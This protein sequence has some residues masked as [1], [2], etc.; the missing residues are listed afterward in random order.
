MKNCGFFNP[1]TMDVRMNYGVEFVDENS[2]SNDVVSKCLNAE[3]YDDSGNKIEK[4]IQ[5][6]NE[7]SRTKVELELENGEIDDY[8]KIYTNYVRI[9]DGDGDFHYD[10][11][12]N[13]QNL[14]HSPF[15]YISSVTNQAN[16]LILKDSY[17]FLTGDKYKKVYD[18]KTKS[19]HNEIDDDKMNSIKQGGILTIYGQVKTYSNDVLS[20]VNTVKL[21]QYQVY[22]VSDDKPKFLIKRIFD[23]TK[24]IVN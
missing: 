11:Y 15:E 12:F 2:E 19:Y 5:L 1:M 8:L 17:L 3:L 14:F 9:D 21:F 22:N 18:G 4:L 7:S 20:D 16:V 23:I 6:S 10:L 24:S 13:I